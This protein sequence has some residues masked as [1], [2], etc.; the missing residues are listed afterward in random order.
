MNH[1][2]EIRRYF[3]TCLEY[4]H[5]NPVIAGLVENPDDWKFSSCRYYTSKSSEGL[6]DFTLVDKFAN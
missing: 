6:I 2:S 5:L 4:V 3:D 1:G